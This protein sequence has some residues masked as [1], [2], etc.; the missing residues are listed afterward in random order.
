M[1]SY[2]DIILGSAGL[3]V[4][5]LLITLYVQFMSDTKEGVSR[6]TYR[7]RIAAIAMGVLSLGYGMN[8][9]ALYP[10]STWGLA[11]IGGAMAAAVWGVAILISIGTGRLFK[12]KKD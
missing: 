8:Q 7:F 3:A 6:A 11:W 9:D 10:Q 1:P 2:D 5:G 4:G 12:R